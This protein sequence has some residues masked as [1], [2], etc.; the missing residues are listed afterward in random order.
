MIKKI[1]SVLSFTLSVLKPFVPFIFIQMIVGIIWAV[2]LAFRPFLIKLLLNKTMVIQPA[3]AV[4]ELGPLALAYIGL[5]VVMMVFLRLHDWA[6]LKISAPLRKHINIIL[7]DRMMNQS[8]HFYQNNFAGA[9][10]NKVSDVCVNIPKLLKIFLDAFYS[11]GIS[12]VASIIA[13]SRV[14]N[15]FALGMLVWILFFVIVSWLFSK[16][17]VSLSDTAATKVTKVVGVVVDI[18]SNMSSVRFFC[19]KAEEKALIK[20][21]L[22]A[23]VHADQTAKYFYMIIYTLQGLSFTIFHGFCVWWL[24]QG[25]RDGW[26]TPGDFALVFTITVHVVNNLWSLSKDI[27]DFSESYGAVSQGLSI[28]RAPIDIQDMPGAKPLVIT[29]GTIV[30]E[31][32]QF[33]YKDALP[34]FQDKSVVIPYGKRVA[35]VGKS[36]SGKSTFVNLILRLFDVNSGRI[37]IDGQDIKTV[38]QDSLREAIGIIPQEPVLFHR[39]IM[40]N[41]RYGKKNAT[42][43][44]VI[45]AAK[46]A[47]AHE[48]IKELPNGYHMVVGERGSK[49]SGGQR[50]RIVIARAFIKN[51][52][53]LILDEATNALDT[54]SEALIQD[55]FSNLMHGKTTIVIAHRLPTLLGMDEIFVFDKGQIIESGTHHTL[56][57]QGGLY[58]NLWYAQTNGVLPA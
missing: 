32:V 25:F 31:H 5:S 18:L 38:T 35:L 4:K 36:G 26:I 24:I 53:I 49:L 27:K 39:S 7:M 23:F 9:V 13:L 58:T 8:H 14:G 21:N 46:K 20:D 47:H 50:Q 30:F 34:F 17:A 28:L 11:H 2:D 48:F 6:W 3:D 43:A 10:S 45:E 52:P 1:N 22:N 19:K 51:P 41:I 44:E 29:Q 57:Q 16:K 42:D 54:I 56:L 55:S 12:V 15:Q 37:L 40:E 33:R